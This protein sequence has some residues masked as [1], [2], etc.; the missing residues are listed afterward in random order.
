[1]IRAYALAQGAGTQALLFLPLMLVL[2]GPVLGLT[3]DVLSS[4]AWA[5]NLVAAEWLIRRRRRALGGGGDR[6]SALATHRALGLAPFTRSAFRFP[7]LL[8]FTVAEAHRRR[9]TQQK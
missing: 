3:R 9:L 1:M 6:A 5:V 8:L 4:A 7:T 2:S